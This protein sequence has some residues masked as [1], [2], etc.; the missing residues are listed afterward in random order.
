MSDFRSGFVVLAGA[1]NV[2]KSTLVNQIL[3]EKVSITAPKPQTTRNRISAILTRPDCQIV[4]VDTPGIHRAKDSFNRILVQTA[5]TTLDEVDL[6]CFIVEAPNASREIN[7]FILGIL[8]RTRTPVILAINKIDLVAKPAL[9]PVMEDYSRRRSFEAIVPV[10]A[11]HDDGVEALL[12]EIVQ[13]LPQGPRYYPD[14]ILTDQP[15]RFLVAELVREKVLHL[16]HQEV[17]YA[18]AVTV[19]EFSEAEGE[20]RIRIEATIHVERDSQKGIL[21]G[22]K[23]A[24]LKEIGSRARR[25]ME[26]LLGCKVFL[27]LFVRV[28]KRWRSDRRVLA[29]FGYHS[30]K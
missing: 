26:R 2:G 11:L 7:D 22:R 1:P 10:S 20:D 27:G 16:T 8:D 24:M 14:D 12:G 21:I 28:Q 23:G 18:V 13:R 3:K 4:F 19:D 5:L 25:D 6:V 9:L 17:P 29:E 30:R 15:E